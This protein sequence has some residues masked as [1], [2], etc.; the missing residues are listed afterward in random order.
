MQHA[1]APLELTQPASSSSSHHPPFW[2]SRPSTVNI[3]TYLFPALKACRRV[4][5][6]TR[7]LF[8]RANSLLQPVPDLESKDCCAYTPVTFENKRQHTIE[9]HLL[10]KACYYRDRDNSTSGIST[11]LFRQTNP[12]R[13]SDWLFRHDCKLAATRLRQLQTFFPIQRYEFFRHPFGQVPLFSFQPSAAH[14]SGTAA[15]EQRLL[16]PLRPFLRPIRSPA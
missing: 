11:F 10:G 5:W 15:P 16:S 8:L 14:R 3:K 7:T 13:H 9:R 4:A 1:Y 12:R 6:T 2:A